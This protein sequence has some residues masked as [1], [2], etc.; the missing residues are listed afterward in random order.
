MP[1]GDSLPLLGAQ[2]SV[3]AFCGN[4]IATVTSTSVGW[5]Y[6]KLMGPNL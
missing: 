6:G 1:F 5:T 2:F 3:M 4:A